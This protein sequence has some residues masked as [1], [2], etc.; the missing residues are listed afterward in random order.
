MERL[1]SFFGLLLLLGICWLFS[2]KK[3]KV[4]FKLI[5]SG[6]LLQFVFAILVLKTTPGVYLFSL[7]NDFVTAILSFSDAG[8]QMVFG[9]D[10]K[11]HF[12]AFS[13]LP[14][15]IFVSA[16]MSVLF[17]L[18]IVQKIVRG[19]ALVMVK[20]MDVSG[21]ESLAAS[22]NIFVGQTEAPLVVKPYI[23]SMTR[24]ELMCLMV[25]GMAT[26]AGGVM[27]AY[28]SFGAEAGHLLA[29]SIMSAP[30]ALVCAKIMVPETEESYT[31]GDVKIDVKP[32]GENVIDAAC[33]GAYDGLN[34]ALNV[35]AMLIVFI[36][37]TALL[38]AGLGF[39]PDVGGAP[40]TFERLLGWAFAPIAFMIGV[41]AEDMW[42]VGM[43]LGKKMFLNE[44]VAYMDLKD[45]KGVVS[46]RGFIIATYALCG[47]SNFS[48]I[49][50]QIGGIGALVPSRRKDL[51]R[52]GFRA[53]IGG[54]IAC[55]M[56]AAIAGILL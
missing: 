36:A 29:A 34:L 11:D 48:S 22:A 37:F 26:I 7:A 47:F 44:F 51:A 20:I 3:S 30:A 28:V 38:N 18:G 41:P 43:L 39:I 9:A 33:A 24:S 16:L 46:E 5:V 21:A 32:Q 15:I 40:L 2:E 17:Y 52:L 6:V 54:T 25:G 35:A 4:N 13:V 31:K 10:F 42:N 53:M 27:A 49:A 56:T 55:L 12:F 1:I 14:T 50:I 23:E 45:L 8:A 19:L